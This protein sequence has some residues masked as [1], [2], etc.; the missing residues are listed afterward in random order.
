[1]KYI[2]LRH[3][4]FTIIFTIVF[5]ISDIYGQQAVIS[6]GGNNNGSGGSSSYTIGQ[7][8]YTTN[9]GTNG[10]VAQGVQ[11]AYEISVIDGIKKANG[12]NLICTTY[13]N[14]ATNFL[15]VEIKNIRVKKMSYE[16]FDL[17]GKL[18]K[19]GLILE[20]ETKIPIYNLV[21]GTYILK[22]FKKSKS[23]KTF[24]IVKNK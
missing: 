1:M 9:T 23:I 7:T 2:N 10:S 15:T 18:I 13:P 14:P 19:K 6:T 12:I 20:N 17:S 5:S 8:V 11:Q 21:N 22:I 4:S 3:L 16:I 24:K